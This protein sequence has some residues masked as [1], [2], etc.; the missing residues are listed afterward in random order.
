ME[1]VQFQSAGLSLSLKMEFTFEVWFT[2]IHGF[3]KVNFPFAS[4]I[5]GTRPDERRSVHHRG[6][7][8]PPLELPSPLLA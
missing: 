1:E 2:S 6:L 8:T 7:F 4:F 3:L 5:D